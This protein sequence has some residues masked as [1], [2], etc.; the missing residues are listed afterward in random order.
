MEEKLNAIVEKFDILQV[1]V[2]NIHTRI[3]KIE[4]DFHNNDSDQSQKVVPDLYSLE[5]L[6][7]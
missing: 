4:N 7:L 1:S 3:E 6:F 5:E 2:N